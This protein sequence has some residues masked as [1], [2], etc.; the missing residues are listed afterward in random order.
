[1]LHV[2]YR[3]LL[4]KRAV[5]LILMHVLCS[6][7]DYAFRLTIILDSGLKISI[8]RTIG[9]FHVTFKWITY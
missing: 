4:F 8:H 7:G 3:R 2:H 6:A 5:V 9:L 1:M